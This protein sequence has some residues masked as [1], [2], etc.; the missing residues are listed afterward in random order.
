MDTP[1]NTVIN[2][3]KKKNPSKQPELFA[4]KPKLTMATE[5]SQEAGRVR[6]EEG[7]IWEQLEDYPLEISY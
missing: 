3:L 2:L 1:K 6:P 5:F 7:N 4:E